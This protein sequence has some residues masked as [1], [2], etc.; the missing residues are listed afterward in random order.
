MDH[1]NPCSE[2]HAST[3]CVDTPYTQRD[4]VDEEAVSSLKSLTFVDINPQRTWLIHSL[5]TITAK[6]RWGVSSL[7]NEVMMEAGILCVM[8]DSTNSKLRMNL[9]W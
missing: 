4:A 5:T 3:L 9:E 1:G 6:W 7:S 2:T 8:R